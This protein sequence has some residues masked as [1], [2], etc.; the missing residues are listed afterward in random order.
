MIGLEQEILKRKHGKKSMPDEKFS[1]TFISKL[2]GISYSAIVKKL[3]DNMFW[4]TEER[5]IFYSIIPKDKQ[6][7][8]VYEYLFTEQK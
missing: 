3:K 6:T 1:I 8:D 7:F 2:L 4:G 5:A